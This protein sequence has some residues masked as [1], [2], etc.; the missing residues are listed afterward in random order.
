M[1]GKFNGTSRTF[2]DRPLWRRD[3]RQLYVGLRAR[4]VPRPVFKMG[5]R[6]TRYLNHWWR[7]CSCKTTLSKPGRFQ[8]HRREAQ[9]C[10]S[11]EC[12]PLRLGRES[13]LLISTGWRN[14]LWTGKGEFGWL[15][16]PVHAAK[17][18]CVSISCSKPIPSPGTLEPTSKVHGCKVNFRL[19][20]IRISHTVL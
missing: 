11:E 3:R 15:A 5:S 10:V 9:V 2:L 4:C 16:A 19:V 6:T 12:L 1:G 8:L 13:M 18:A 7:L 17:S 20:P 14:K